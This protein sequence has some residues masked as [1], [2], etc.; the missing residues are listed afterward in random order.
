MQRTVL[1]FS[2]IELSV[3]LAVAGILGSLAFSGLPTWVD[4]LRADAALNGLRGALNIA[5]HTAII[6][7]TDVIVCPRAGNVCGPRNSWHEGTLVFEDHD[8]DRDYTEGDMMVTQLPPI[9]SGYVVWRAFRSRS[10]LRFTGR[11]MTDWQNGHL[12]YCPNDGDTQHARQV[13]L[14]YAGR[15]YPSR[16]SDGDGIHEDVQGEPLTC[17]S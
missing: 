12:R 1:G 9:T 4:H 6:K 13:V 17:A 15:T 2:L 8:A 16:D 14:N 3:V 5:R 10:Y 7:N 11:G